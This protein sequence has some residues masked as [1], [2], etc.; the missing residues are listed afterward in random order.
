[1][2]AHIPLYAGE[3]SARFSRSLS[4][5]AQPAVSGPGQQI[6]CYSRSRM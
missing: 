6:A 2:A 5:L 1:M 3:S 4:L